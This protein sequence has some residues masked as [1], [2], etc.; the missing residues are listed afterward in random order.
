MYQ[1]RSPTKLAAKSVIKTAPKTAKNPKF[2]KGTPTVSTPPPGSIV[3]PNFV[4]NETLVIPPV[5]N[6]ELPLLPIVTLSSPRSPLALIAGPKGS[7]GPAGPKGI[8]TR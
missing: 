4:V 6:V 8:L 1:T 2:A 3:A 5:S 7:I